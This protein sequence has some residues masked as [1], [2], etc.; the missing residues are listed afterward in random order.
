MMIAS[1]QDVDIIFKAMKLHAERDVVT[2]I[3]RANIQN[4]KPTNHAPIN[5]QQPSFINKQMERKKQINT[6]HGRSPHNVIVILVIITVVAIIT[7]I[8]VV[9]IVVVVAVIWL[10]SLWLGSSF[11]PR[12]ASCFTR[13]RCP[14]RRQGVHLQCRP[15]LPAPSPPFLP[16]PREQGV[17]ARPV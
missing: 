15:L 14:H 6:G 10:K 8:V 16:A 13:G 5:K 17:A 4:R 9:V 11:A 1:R 12:S 7:T 2:E 3:Q